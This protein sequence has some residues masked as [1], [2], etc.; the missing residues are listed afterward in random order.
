MTDTV[1]NCPSTIQIRQQGF[2]QGLNRLGKLNGLNWLGILQGL[3]W[4]GI[5]YRK[6]SEKAADAFILFESRRKEHVLL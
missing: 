2:G 6:I 5:V 1:H 4:L 3:K